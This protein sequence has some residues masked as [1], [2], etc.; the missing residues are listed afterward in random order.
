MQCL[1]HAV[2]IAK[3]DF[4]DIG[5]LLRG[6]FTLARILIVDD[7]PDISFILKI[8][9][10]KR[11]GFRVDSFNDPEEALHN[12][13]PGLYDLVIIDI[14]PKMDGMELYNKMH[15]VDENIRIC[16]MCANEQYYE[17]IRD[18]LKFHH[19]TKLF[20]PSKAIWKR[21]VIA[22]CRQIGFGSK[23]FTFRILILQCLV[24][25]IKGTDKTNLKIKR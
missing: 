8:M 20:F 1:K 23:Q 15:K 17:D 11:K 2:T 24:L 5:L 12:F 4:V 19:A 10:E 13:R 7:E 25:Y 14:K 6:E 16:F 21:R 22:K 18:Q 9:L 3:K